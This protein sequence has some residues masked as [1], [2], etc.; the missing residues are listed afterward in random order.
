MNNEQ[1][2]YKLKP[3]EKN[4][5]VTHIAS[6]IDEHY[7]NFI[8]YIAT[9]LKK[10]A[11]VNIPEKTHMFKTQNVDF[12]TYETGILAKAKSGPFDGL[13]KDISGDSFFNNKG[14]KIFQTISEQPEDDISFFVTVTNL[15]IVS[16]NHESE[17][18]NYVFASYDENEK[19]LKA[20]TAF[21]LHKQIEMKYI[22]QSEEPTK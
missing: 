8:H 14:K 3:V 15:G 18:D 19:P 7:D 11:L 4:E 22:K 1:L 6:S 5:N 12:T 20:G 10:D 9:M 16:K 2:I 21:E 13:D 17:L